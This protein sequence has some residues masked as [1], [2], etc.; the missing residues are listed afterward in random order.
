MGWVDD[1]SNG[2]AALYKCRPEEDTLDQSNRLLPTMSAHQGALSLLPVSSAS[3]TVVL[4]Q[5]DLDFT[6][7]Q[8]PLLHRG[9]PEY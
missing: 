9:D 1:L 2:Q 4:Y 6:P 8:Y 7:T 3:A 5:V